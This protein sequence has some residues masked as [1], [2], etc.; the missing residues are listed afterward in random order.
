M[1]A[2]SINKTDVVLVVEDN[3]KSRKLLAAQLEL[4]GFTVL[5]AAN[6]AEG[7]SIACQLEPDIILMDLFMPVMS[8]LDAIRML[9]E[10]P[11][12]KHIPIITVTAN[13]QRKDIVKVLEAGAI[14]YIIKPFFMPELKARVKSVLMSKRFYDDRCRAEKA[15]KESE[16]KYRQLVES[17]PDWVWTCDVEGR[18]TYTNQAIKGL[19]GY[20]ADEI[21]GNS[22]FELIHMEDRTRCRKC[23]QKATEEK[24]GWKDVVVRYLHKNGSVKFFEA[25]GQPIFDGNGN[26]MGF[27]G[28]DR[29]IT[30]RRRAEE[31]K[32][33]LE[34]QLRH[35]QKNGSHRYFGR[36]P[37][38]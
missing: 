12:L 24:T 29:D 31:E 9:K 4:E 33:E 27:S 15:L 10:N 2:P 3:A 20:E 1:N 35:A 17:T 23:F 11:D 22:I 18:Q 21:V 5:T 16:I 8:G 28:I 30:E 38:P 34:T 25:R 14:D 13:D 36:R 37:C 6:G 19:L 32:R 26:L 7:V